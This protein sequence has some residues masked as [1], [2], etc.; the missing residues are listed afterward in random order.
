MLVLHSPLTFVHLEH[1][2]VFSIIWKSTQFWADKIFVLGVS[3][4][5]KSFSICNTRNQEPVEIFGRIHKKL[6][7]SKHS[8]SINNET[9]NPSYLEILLATVLASLCPTLNNKFTVRPSLVSLST[10]NQNGWPWTSD[11]QYANCANAELDYAKAMR[12]LFQGHILFED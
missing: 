8:N 9:G 2:L 1:S 4:V 12:T 11:S 3:I 7:T 5:S 10:Q 6:M